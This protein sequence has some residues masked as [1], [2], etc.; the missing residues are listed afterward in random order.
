MGTE[1]PSH[2]QVVLD[3]TGP[4]PCSRLLSTEHNAH[5]EGFIMDPSHQHAGVHPLGFKIL[6]ISQLVFQCRALALPKDIRPPAS[7]SIPP[8]AA[9]QPSPKMSTV[10]TSQIKEKNA[11]D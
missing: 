3:E 2:P 4:N 8:K 9:T 6:S 11:F 10:A 7:A 1:A 5:N